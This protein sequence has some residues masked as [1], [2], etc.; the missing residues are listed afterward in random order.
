MN[1]SLT[2]TTALLLVT[3]V[4]VA[5]CSSDAKKDPGAAPTGSGAQAAACEGT[6]TPGGTLV[7]AKQNE[8]LSL[9]PYNTPGG[10]GDTEALNMIYEGLVRMDPSGKTQDIVPAIAE[11]WET[12]ADGKSYTFHL[13]G[14]AKFSDGAPVTAA[15]V[16]YSLDT[17]ADPKKNSWAAFAAGYKSAT[18]LDPAT[19]RIDL[20]EPTG[21]FLYSLAMVAASI[22]PAKAEAQGKAFFEKP[23][24]SG[25]F[26]VLSWTKGSSITFG[27]NDQYWEPGV[28]RLDKIV[29]NF[30]TDDNTRML[31]LR[32]GQAQL[33]DSVPFAQSASLQSEKGVHIDAFKIASWILLSLNHQ[34]PQ[35]KDLG[36]RQALSSAIDRAAVNEKIYNGLGEIPN[37]PLPRLKYDASDSEVAPAAFD[38]AKAKD[39]MAKSG[40]A[41]GFK[42][43][44]EYPSGNA[45]F[46][47]LALVLKEA[48]SQLGVDL[49]LHPEDQATLSKSFNGGTYDVILPYAFAASDVPIPDEFATF[50]AIP[51]GTNGFFSWWSD[52]KIAAMTTAFVHTT[53]EA[54]RA[55]QWPKIQAAL[56]EQQPVINVLDLPLLEARRDA[57]CDFAAN[58]TGNSSFGRTWLVK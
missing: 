37:S 50:Y 27:K 19:V 45:A 5:A 21:G 12:A 39:L 10:F 6:P 46:Q 49:S 44:L 14:N 48:W 23:V 29:V 36:V 35:F 28:P 25:P 42:A 16:K 11:K 15:D 58:A 30:V 52:P 40:F 47:S 8:T 20:S 38:V 51:G 33:V 17:W 22:L 2:A 57:V 13:R 3:S 55:E 31:A 54:S 53:D 34:K 18:V 32:S 9:S 4:G 26:K 1:R 24:G 43:K 41:D 7:A 56:Q